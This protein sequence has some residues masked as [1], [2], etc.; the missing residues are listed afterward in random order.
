LVAFAHQLS[1]MY[2]LKPKLPI[3]NFSPSKFLAQAL[4]SKFSIC[5]FRPCKILVQDGSSMLKFKKE[6]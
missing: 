5:N 4:K 6:P 1:H 2:A 3:C